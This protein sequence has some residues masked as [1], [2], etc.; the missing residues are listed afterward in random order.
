MCRLPFLLPFSISSRMWSEWGARAQLM[1]LA[2]AVEQFLMLLFHACVSLFLLSR[3]R[4]PA[5]NFPAPPTPLSKY[6]RVVQVTFE[7]C[8]Q[9]HAIFHVTQTCVYCWSYTLWQGHPNARYFGHLRTLSV[10]L[11]RE[12]LEGESGRKGNILFSVAL[13]RQRYIVAS[14]KC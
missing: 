12:F 11:V 13:Q 4:T 6:S 2:A 5:M 9:S 7:N 10:S 1:S 14:F 3:S 8:V